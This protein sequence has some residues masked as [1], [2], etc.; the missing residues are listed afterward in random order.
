MRKHSHL[1]TG[2]SLDLAGE[3]LISKQLPVSLKHSESSPAKYLIPH[4]I[5]AQGSSHWLEKP[6]PREDWIWLKTDR[7]WGRCILAQLGANTRPLL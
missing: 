6:G 7:A 3:N 1:S 4:Q 2:G 5:T